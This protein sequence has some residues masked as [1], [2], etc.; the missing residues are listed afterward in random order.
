MN[1]ELNAGGGSS[2]FI[3]Q[4]DSSFITHHSSFSSSPYSARLLVSFRVT[5]S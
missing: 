3:A 5:Q 4:S 1:D 2:A